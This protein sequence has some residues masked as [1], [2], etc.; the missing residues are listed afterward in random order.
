M[1]GSGHARDATANYSN[2]S[3]ADVTALA[4]WKT[5]DS[6]V[7]VV[8]NKPEDAGTVTALS[9]GS[10]SITASYDGQDDSANITVSAASC[11]G[12]PDSIVIDSGDQVVAE[13]DRV[14]FTARAIYL[15]GCEEDITD[16]NQTVWQS[17]DKK[18]CDFISP[19]GG[20]IAEG[21]R[22]GVATVEAKHRGLTDTATCTVTPR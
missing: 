18:T 9:Q 13:G 3:S 17:L 8:S 21:L 5:A 12:R 22:T 10:T 19:K 4:I 1:P 20:G 2:G 11:T 15:S 6:D 14:R 7:A 16:S